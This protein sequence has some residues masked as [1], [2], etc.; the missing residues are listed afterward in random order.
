[1]FNR[2]YSYIITNSHKNKDM[3]LFLTAFMFLPEAKYYELN[4]KPQDQITNYYIE[5]GIEPSSDTMK[6]YLNFE[7]SLKEY[8]KAQKDNNESE[9]VAS[10]AIG[11][12]DV[13]KAK[14]LGSTVRNSKDTIGFGMN[15]LMKNGL[16]KAGASG[17]LGN[18]Q[19]ESGLNTGAIGDGGTSFGVAQWHN[20]RWDALKQYANSKNADI[21]N[22]ETQLGFLLQEL[23]SPKYSDLM[24]KLSNTEDPIE[25]ARLF[26]YKFERPAKYDFARE[27]NA[28]KIYQRG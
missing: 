15:F 14:Q 22:I 6:N 25:A 9:I 11:D 27:N 18:L 23:K 4:A 7:S 1:M 28:K 19:K 26:S 8:Q 12:E 24:N 20:Q 21:K 2:L 10:P 16:S 3:I 17:I 13:Q 5:N